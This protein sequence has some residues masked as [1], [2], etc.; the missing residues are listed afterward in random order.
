M[1]QKKTFTVSIAGLKRKL[2][3]FEVT[4]GVKIA[5]FNILGDTE[6]V[7]HAA[8][9]LAKKIPKNIGVLVTPEV[10]SIPLVFELSK[11]LQIPYIV[12]RKIIK[13]YM[14]NSLKSETVSITTGKPQTL[15]LDGKDRKT[16]K[17][18]R[19]VLVDDVVSTG[20]TLEGLRQ[21]MKKA[22]ALVVGEAA[23]FTEGE[24]KKWKHV[25]SLGHLPIFIEKNKK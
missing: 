2:P 1:F 15:W 11:I 12:V 7:V 9:A 13:P 17:G 23:V 4:P 6:V 21:L 8:Q 16:L 19:V 3:L 22:G 20:N 5:L 18:K 14:V 10:K 24:K 25:I